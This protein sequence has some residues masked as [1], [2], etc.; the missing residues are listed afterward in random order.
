MLAD[1]YL[2]ALEYGRAAG[3]ANTDL[4]ERAGLALSDAGDRAAALAG[5]LAAVR[6][7]EAALELLPDD[8]EDRAPLLL[9]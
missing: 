2:N 3:G 1:H 4:A 8:A 9:T 7:Y 6:F 5:Y